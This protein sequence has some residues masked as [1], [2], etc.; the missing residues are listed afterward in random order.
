MNPLAWRAVH[1][2]H[3]AVSLLNLSALAAL[4]GTLVPFFPD[5]VRHSLGAFAVVGGYA[6]NLLAVGVGALA[7]AWVGWSMLRGQGRSVWARHRLGV[8][9]AVFVVMCWGLV[10]AWGRLL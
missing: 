9:N 3:I 7:A 6:A 10:F 4:L 5:A 8:F 1:P 2:F